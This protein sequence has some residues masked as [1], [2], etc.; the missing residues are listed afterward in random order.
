VIVV[1]VLADGR[2]RRLGSQRVTEGRCSAGGTGWLQGRVRLYN[3]R[4]T[5]E[6]GENLGL[7][8]TG[9]GENVGL[10]SR[11]NGGNMCLARTG[12]GEIVKWGRWGKLWDMLP[13]GVGR[14]WDSL[15]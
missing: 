2:F 9:S 3:I 1:P 6:V 15:L 12:I 5:H 8:P 4:F 11:G 10:T 14:M 13:W 7:A